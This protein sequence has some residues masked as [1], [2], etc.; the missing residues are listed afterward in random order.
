MRR[1]CSD[2]SISLSLSV[3]SAYARDRIL[4]VLTKSITYLNTANLTRSQSS[5]SLA[6]AIISLVGLDSH[7]VI[8]RF[9]CVSDLLVNSSP[10]RLEPS[11]R[12]I[13]QC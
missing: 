2:W 3:L 6:V 9:K 5:A 8:L 13:S 4:F 1:R 10:E 7:L 12:L 11:A